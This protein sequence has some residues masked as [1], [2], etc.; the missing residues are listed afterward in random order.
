MGIK[1]EIGDRNNDFVLL[2]KHNRIKYLYAFGSSVANDFSP[3]N[4]DIDL[5]VELETTDPLTKG[6]TL[7]RL[8]DQFEDFFKEK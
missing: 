8:W 3:E 4:S 1:S 2:C 7:I 5:L 6:E